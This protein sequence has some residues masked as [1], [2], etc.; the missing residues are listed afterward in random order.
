MIP[1]AP[2]DGGA[3]FAELARERSTG[4]SGPQGG[5]LGYFTQEQMVPEFA[6]VAFALEAG[7]YTNEPVQTQFGWHVIKVEDRRQTEPAPFEE[8]EEQLREEVS[9]EVINAVIGE[10]RQNATIEVVDP[11]PLATDQ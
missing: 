2:L 7:T 6:Q 8:V 3:D 9:R 5:D 1:L 11:L 4:P 10:L